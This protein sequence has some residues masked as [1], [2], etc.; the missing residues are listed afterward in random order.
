MAI[1]APLTSSETVTLSVEALRVAPPVLSEPAGALVPPLPRPLPRL[2][3]H[4]HV[5][6]PVAEAAAP[7]PEEV[8]HLLPPAE[9]VAANAINGA[10]HGRSSMRSGFA[11]RNNVDTDATLDTVLS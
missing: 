5:P 4:V 6:E 1:A 2:P 9:A 10:N 7:A 3:R 8:A 11:L